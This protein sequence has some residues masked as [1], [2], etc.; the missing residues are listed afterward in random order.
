MVVAALALLGGC[1]S[2]GADG[3]RGA[4]GQDGADGQ[5]GAPGQNGADG[6]DGAPGQDGTD[7]MDGIDGS[8][9][10]VSPTEQCTVCHD[11]GSLADVQ[12]VHPGLHA[13]QNLDLEI[14]EVA[15]DG[16]RAAQVTFTVYDADTGLPVQN[17]TMDPIRIMFNQFEPAAQPYNPDL[18][19]EDFLYERGSTTDANLRLVQNAPG[20]YTYT[21]LETID[22]AI[23]ND[24]ADETLNQQV[25]MRIR[26]FFNY[27][28]V[29]D[30]Y[31][32]TGLPAASTVATEVAD[33]VN[34]L[35][36]TD[37]CETCH[38]PR[39]GNVGHG[40][41]YNKVEYCRN[42]HTAANGTRAT[43]GTDL[44]T[45]IHQIH[46]AVD[47]TNGGADPG[48]DWTHVTYPQDVNNCEKCH[49]GDDADIWKMKPTI[50]ACG[51]CHWD[52]D[53]T[54]G[55]N[56]PAG[57]QQNDDCQT[58]HEP[59]TLP[60]DVSHASEN[61]T[62]HNPLVEL[63]ASTIT[64]EINSV[65]VDGMG[66]PT[67]N[68]SIYEDGTPFTGLDTTFPP[69]GYTGSPNF[70]LAYALP[71]DGIDEPA[72]WNNLGEFKSQPI[73]IGMDDV[74]A[75]SDISDAGGGTYDAVLNGV[76]FPA[77][78]TMR[79]VAIDGYFTQ[80]ST[81]LSRHAPSVVMAVDGDVERRAII[82]FNG[83]LDCHERLELHGGNRVIAPETALESVAVCV[84]CHNP[85][86]S[87]SGNTFD[88]A[89]YMANPGDYNS[90]SDATVANYGDDPFA[91]PE[92]AQNFKELV[93]GIHGSDVR[94]TP[95]EHVRIRGGNAYSYDWSHVT[96][97]GD[98]SNC[99]KCHLDESYLPEEIPETALMT[100]VKTGMPMTF[101]E[102][103]TV[104]EDLP[105]DEDTV[106][107]PLVGACRA[108]HI[109]EE[110][111][112]HIDQFGGKI[113][114]TRFDVLNP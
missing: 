62:P 29:N 12:E 100:T 110:I 39:I 71:Q 28:A 66:V 67:V 50:E 10:T 46:A 54:T 104:R 95:Y 59:N 108:C 47:H 53:F 34:E 78:A 3:A 98:A 58:C 14:I 74:A 94:Q 32:I 92:D 57:I 101:A 103:T 2:D 105:N 36:S 33:P 91:W 83:C 75:N 93:H 11:S 79:A 85:N 8:D 19:S 89:D 44:V 113:G 20:E 38:G 26:G 102:A 97:P 40:G 6:Q 87:S 70:R 81:S 60:I 73:S 43:N 42:C 106:I 90:S 99:S 114:M 96:F 109:G 49:Q 76:A 64:Y 68:F 15:A 5:D 111:N 18:W 63:G 16:S 24:G 7:G 22:E 37:A 107:S 35:V 88:I 21:F 41:G 30:I 86:L 45:M 55:M 9:A 27:N 25:S 13:G 84:T 72:D 51:S 65:T 82:D 69:T 61:S 48:H 56:H 77:N 80:T 1:G 17:M 4:P 52:V 23:T 31:Q 112:A